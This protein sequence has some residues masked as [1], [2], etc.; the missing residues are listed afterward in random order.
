MTTVDGM[1]DRAISEIEAHR[2]RLIELAKKI[3]AHPELA[4]REYKACSWLMEEL[5]RAG[6]E[7]EAGVLELE[8]AFRATCPGRSERPRIA[9]LAEYDALPKI[10]HACGHNL[11]G[12]SAVGV[13]YGLRGLISELDGTLVVLGTPGEE[14]GGGKI[15]LIERGAFRDLDAAMMIHPGSKTVIGKGSLAVTEVD[16]SFKGRAAHAAVVP[17]KGINA[18]DAV[19][20]T[21]NHINALRQHL[22]EDVRIH[23]IITDGGAAPNVV[24]ETA[25]ARFI[26]RTI[27]QPFLPELE[28]KVKN[29]ARAACLATGAEV[30]FR[31]RMYPYDAMTLNPPLD[32]LIRENMTHLGL[33]IDPL[34]KRGGMGST[35][36]GNVSQVLPASHPGIS[37][38]PKTMAGHSQE[39]R[40]A[41]ISERGFEGMLLA[42]KV[43]AMT[44]IDLL[45]CPEAMVCVRKAF[46]GR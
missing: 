24:P 14:G 21:F 34:P 9:V 45:T 4:M 17:E 2:E 46:D 41:A 13:A 20:G 18:L 23:G 30:E 37:I 38:G 35:D 42:A 3:H 6:L 15:I 7:V 39:M 22:P 29:C 40:A 33:E 16:M 5:T 12:T 32:D 1:K 31:E 27:E 44:T 19:I 26:V 36:M 11:I 25:A 43:M 10:G 8:T 28:E